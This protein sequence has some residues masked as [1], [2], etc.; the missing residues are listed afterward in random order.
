MRWLVIAAALLALPPPTPVG[1]RVGVDAVLDRRRG[2]VPRRFDRWG[3]FIL[4]V[5]VLAFVPWPWSVAVAAAGGALALRLL[6]SEFSTGAAK[7]ELALARTLPD[8]VDLLAAVL[9]VGLTDADAIALVAAATPEPLGGQLRA[10]AAHRRLGAAPTAAWRVVAH[11]PALTD[12]AAAMTRHADTGAAIAPLLE[13]V[14]ADAR[15]DYFSRAQA[16]ARSAA[17]RA[18]IPL[19]A[20]FLPSF[21]L[22]G[23]VPIVAALTAGLTF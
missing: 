16:A 1:R 3:A 11:T 6:P 4:C 10:V 5:A 12:L 22:L 23:V 21:A 8:A 17:V 7:H 2:R 14:A 19:A 13:R 15:R 9:R 20:C 18:V